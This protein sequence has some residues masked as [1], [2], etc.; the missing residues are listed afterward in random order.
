MSGFTALCFAHMINVPYVD[1][2]IVLSH[3]NVIDMI[4]KRRL[5]WLGH[6]IKRNSTYSDSFK[7]IFQNDEIRKVRRV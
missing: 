6:I 2:S 1:M 7:I 3:T 5:K 4:E